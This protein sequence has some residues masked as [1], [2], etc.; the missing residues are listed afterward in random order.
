MP[1]RRVRQHVQ[2]TDI[3]MVQV[4][5]R[6]RRPPETVPKR[7]SD[8]SSGE[9]R[10]PIA[11]DTYLGSG[12]GDKMTVRGNRDAF[13][14]VR[15]CPRALVDVSSKSTRDCSCSDASAPFR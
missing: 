4:G 6:A 2:R 13:A 15:L 3:R 11:A 5:N 9:T 10:L 1:C 12:V 7:A 14:Y 8:E